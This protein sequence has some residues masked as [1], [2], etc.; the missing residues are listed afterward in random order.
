MSAIPIGDGHYDA[1]AREM[2]EQDNEYGQAC[3]HAV[4]GNIDRALALLEV[5]LQSGDPVWLG[6]ARIAPEFAFL[7]DEPRF[8]A[9]VGAER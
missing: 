2:A 3:F 9:L 4:S 6:W 5:A 8:H 7:V 1:I